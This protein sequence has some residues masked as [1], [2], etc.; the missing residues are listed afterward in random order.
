MVFSL[1]GSSGSK[2]PPQD[3]ASVWTHL[4]ALRYEP[5]SVGSRHLQK[6][7]LNLFWLLRI[8]IIFKKS[9]GKY[10]QNDKKNCFNAK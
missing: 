2:K 10:V 1:R 5:S 6:K 7:T 9:R 8:R 4:R 3:S